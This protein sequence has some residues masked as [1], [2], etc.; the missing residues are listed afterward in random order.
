[1]GR[2][3]HRIYEPEIWQPAG[4]HRVLKK[5]SDFLDADY[6]NLYFCRLRLRNAFS[7]AKKTQFYATGAVGFH[8]FFD[9]MTEI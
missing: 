1:M 6:E 9:P 5:D 4:E 3:L 8:G 7:W 2:P